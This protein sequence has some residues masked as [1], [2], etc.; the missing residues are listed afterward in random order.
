MLENQHPIL[1]PHLD[2]LADE[3]VR[4]SNAWADCPICM[5]QRAT[6][7]TGMTGSTLGVTTNF[8]HRTPVESCRSLPSLLRERGGYQCVWIGKTHVIP[9]RSRFGFDDVILH[10]D[11]Y[12][13]HLEDAGFG[14]L[15]RGH[16]IGGNEVVPAPNPLPET[17]TSSRWITDRAVEF[18]YRRDPETPFFLWII[19]E[20]PHP[21][22]DPPQ[23][24][25]R[26]YD[27]QRIPEP[28]QAPWGRSDEPNAFTR[29]R[30]MHNWDRISPDWIA[31]IRRQYYAQQTF[32]DYNLGRLFGEL[33]TRG[34]W[35]DTAVVFNSDHGE[36][37]G[38]F[39]LFGKIGRAHV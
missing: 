33:K 31:E 2:Q 22:F 25:E 34:L 39:G 10:P 17:L 36:H 5:P 1:T 26:L 14:G 38:D 11:D 9:E 18:M 7:L 20:A 8:H 19:Y 21:P 35:D 15:F 28:I 12:V 32:I 30:L 6:L 16:G 27:R 3:G 23:S 29:R 13:N 37:L 24:Y 4:F